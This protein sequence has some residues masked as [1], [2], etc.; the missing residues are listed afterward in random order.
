MGTLLWRRL[1]HPGEYLHIKCTVNV[2]P[3]CK[4]ARGR[5]QV[6]ERGP[7]IGSREVPLNVPG[8][9]VEP[10]I[11]ASRAGPPRSAVLEGLAQRKRKRGCRTLRKRCGQAERVTRP[12]DHAM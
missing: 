6:Q 12:W 1:R 7:G 11:D 2:L 3:E 9:G 5:A 8:G 10:R 4:D